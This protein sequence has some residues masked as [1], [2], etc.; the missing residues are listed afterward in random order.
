MDATGGTSAGIMPAIPA[1]W[2][3]KAIV[4]NSRMTSREEI[5][6][7]REAGSNLFYSSLFMPTK[8]FTNTGE[9]TLLKKF[10]WIK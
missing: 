1:R 3:D 7:C 8:Y 2:K 4:A 10:G 9:N 6:A 5:F